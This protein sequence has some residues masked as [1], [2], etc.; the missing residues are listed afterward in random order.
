[1][2]RTDRQLPLYL[3]ARHDCSYLPGRQSST[4]FTDP[5]RTPRSQDYAE[6]LQ[7]GFRRSGGMIYAPRCDACTQCK[8]VRLP[9]EAFSL[10]RSHRRILRRNQDIA[11]VER[12]AGFDEQH[13]TLYRTYTAARHPDGDMASASPDDYLGFLCTDW[14][15]THFLEF[16]LDERLIAVA[17][18]DRP[19]SALSSVYT[20]F[21]PTLTDRSLGTLAIL[22]QV[23]WAQRLGLPHLYLGYWIRDSPKM[24]YKSRFRPIE[25]WHQARWQRFEQDEELPGPDDE[26]SR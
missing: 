18:T 16:R 21:D 12:E 23:E 3:S 17:V 2:N 6:L 10:R 5:Q 4:L 20:F 13:Y 1:M 7:F 11:V 15:D 25:V 14:C 19:G 8:S 22:K 9:V 24:A 26:I